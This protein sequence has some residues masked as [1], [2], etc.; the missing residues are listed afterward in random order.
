[1]VD[2]IK[3][4]Q[5]AF[6]EFLTQETSSFAVLLYSE[7]LKHALL[8][9]LSVEEL[10]EIGIVA[11]FL[12]EGRMPETIP[13]PRA[14]FVLPNPGKLKE[15]PFAAG[16]SIAK[17]N[18]LLFTSA[19]PD[20]LV[21]LSRFLGAIPE[22][23][24]IIFTQALSC[25]P[26]SPTFFVVPPP[27]SLFKALILPGAPQLNKEIE[28]TRESIVSALQLGDM[29]IK[30]IVTL[31][32]MADLLE[33]FSPLIN[34]S[35]S[36]SSDDT[37]L[38]VIDRTYDPLPLLWHTYEYGNLVENI[39]NPG[40]DQRIVISEKRR[41]MSDDFWKEN[42]KYEL[43]YVSEMLDS[44]MRKRRSAGKGSAIGAKKE[45]L[46][47]KGSIDMH[48][49]I[50]E[51]VIKSIEAYEISDF[52]ETEQMIMMGQTKAQEM[53]NKL[54]SR[55]TY[56]PIDQ[57][58]LFFI[59]E[60]LI[61]RGSTG[62]A[63]EFVSER[64]KSSYGF[65]LRESPVYTSLGRAR[66]SEFQEGKKG[67]SSLDGIIPRV[68]IS[69]ET[70]NMFG[71]NRA[72]YYKYGACGIVSKILVESGAGFDARKGLEFKEI[73]TFGGQFRN[74]MVFVC[75]PTNGHEHRILEFRMK[76]M[77]GGKLEKFIFG[78]T[79]SESSKSFVLGESLRL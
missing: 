55:E 72:L 34:E 15:S 23:A 68:K 16:I 43:P 11:T 65:D 74:L 32:S 78:G 37:L 51:T 4:Q 38:I 14:I 26:I 53:V 70:E 20:S 48:L 42:A 24:R 63:E 5:R 12:I 60:L 44:E 19:P 35:S 13:G 39:Y 3:T 6:K 2:L 25:I 18:T 41:N 47:K 46:K 7:P 56:D 52:V 22:N 75:G 30:K 66:S 9:L 54:L 62:K 69:K 61:G 64:V 57:A 10:L 31:S 59:S 67:W 17:D 27:C 36:P 28:K 40:T 1:M 79:S 73:G 29:A 50:A 45:A 8:P 77:F 21:P 76:E 71:E 33:L 49:A 58:R